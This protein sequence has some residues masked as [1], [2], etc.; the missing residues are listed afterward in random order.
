MVAT[1]PT[2]FTVDGIPYGVRTVIIERAGPVHVD[3]IKL[4]E[5]STRGKGF[6]QELADGRF[7]V[8]AK[9][10]HCGVKNRN[11]RIY[12]ARVWERHLVPGTPFQGRVG[13]R[14]M[15][16]HLEHPT[17][18]KSQM[19]LGAIV[20]TEASPPDENGEVWITFETLST[21]P[22][23]VVEAYIRDRVRFGL[24]SRGN[25]SVKSREGVDEVQDDF[26][27]LTWDCVIDE[28]T[29]GAEVAA[30]ENLRERTGTVEELRKFIAEAKKSLDAYVSNLTERAGGDAAK[31]AQL[32]EADARKAAE[33]AIDCKGGVC[34][35]PLTESVVPPSG[36]SKYLLAFED[37][38]AHYRAYQGTTGQWEVWMHPHNLAAERLASKIPTLDAC[39]MVAE[40]HYKLVLASGAMSAQSHAEHSNAIGREAASVAPNTVHAPAIG[41]MAGMMGRYSQPVGPGP[42]TGGRMPKIVLSFESIR[43]QWEK[44]LAKLQETWKDVLTLPYS[45][46]VMHVT[47]QPPNTSTFPVIR[48]AGMVASPVRP[49][50]VEVYSS[51]ESGPHAVS[52][53][54]RV[55]SEAGVKARVAAV[56][57]ISRGRVIGEANIMG[58]KWR[59]A[60]EQQVREAGNDDKQPGEMAGGDTVPEPTGKTP[61][62]IDPEYKGE[63]PMDLDLDLDV[64]EELEGAGRETDDTDEPAYGDGPDLEAGADVSEDDDEFGDMPMDVGMD[65]E[66]YSDDYLADFGDDDD[67]MDGA[68][69]ATNRTEDAMA[70]DE[71]ALKEA[72]AMFSKLMESP[73]GRSA[74]KAMFAKA[75]SRTGGPGDA[76]RKA[77]SSKGGKTY[78]RSFRASYAKK[79]GLNPKAALQTGARKQP[80]KPGK[81]ESVEQ[82]A[83][84]LTFTRRLNETGGPVTGAVRIWFNKADRP[85]RYE[86][87]NREG[88]LESVANRKMRVIH[89]ALAEGQSTTIAKNEQWVGEDGA[90]YTPRK[91]IALGEEDLPGRHGGDT[92]VVVKG[93]EYKGKEGPEYSTID[94]METPG[95]RGEEGDGLEPGDYDDATSAGD[96]KV[97][98]TGTWPTSGSPIAMPSEGRRISH[99]SD[100]TEEKDDKD[101]EKDKDDKDESLTSEELAHLREK[102]SFLEGE[103]ARYETLCQE[104][105]ETIEALRESAL[106]AE[107]ERARAEAFEKHPEL[108]RVEARLMRCE[109]VEA[110]EEEVSGLVALV[111]ANAPPPTTPSLVE[112]NGAGS[113]STPRDGVPPEGVLMESSSPFS[114]R[115][116]TGTRLGTGDVASRVA[117]HRKRRRG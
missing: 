61:D 50:V 51:F 92:G 111:E 16:G 5:Q 116:S 6:I 1:S 60:H 105:H 69:E 57:K 47:S 81:K 90:V 28:S 98:K 59:M 45:G 25:G 53:L 19:P 113:S 11:N 95:D 20:V 74:M 77:R 40:N 107:L 24:S 78:Y 12:P 91:I 37:G 73:K 33:S 23:R 66:P 104:Q 34:K 8:R 100:V 26:D 86:F 27:P 62:G 44:A 67:M 31:A 46:T 63:D 64:N 38:S 17:D 32:A 36:Y 106:L 93:D 52:H 87:Y 75:F 35:C 115:L 7:R 15:I 21:P 3:P 30:D 108:R 13:S 84:Y 94:G 71:A 2:E 117:A 99:R 9:A 22:G 43:P 103:L 41:G 85:M 68:Y 42:V 39:Q 96:G 114:D 56:G 110:L 76:A 109:S 48:R 82:R 80:P 29:I 101:D 88:I 4:F 102:N 70:Q 14:G 54:R 65:D 58:I 18:G 49:G 112:R 97:V 83:Y 55:L 10:Q 72:Q 79:H 89:S